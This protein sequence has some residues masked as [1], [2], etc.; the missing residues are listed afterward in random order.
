MNINEMELG[1]VS[2]WS[3]LH[4]LIALIL[5][6]V[7]IVAGFY[8]YVIQDQQRY[9]KTL[10][11]KE[12]TLKKEFQTKAGL[13]SS[14]GDYRDQIKEVAIILNGLIN[15]LPSKKELARLLDD[16][17][18]IGNQNGLQF[19]SLNWGMKKQLALADE[20]PISI[21]VVGSYQQLGHFT[22]DIASLSRIVILDNLRLTRYDENV[23]LLDIV[24]KTYRYQENE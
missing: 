17:G 14:L 3:T 11:E 4:K 20:I 1:N 12:L 22:A 16:I 5:V 15:K 21:K 24:A 7:A 10:Y 23:L 18:F 6:C 13:A 8:F 9:L 19:Q 2:S